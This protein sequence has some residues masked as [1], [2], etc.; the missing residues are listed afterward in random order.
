MN[1]NFLLSNFSGAK[2]QAKSRDIPPKSL[3]SLGFEGHAE[4]L[5]PP[6]P[7]LTQKTPTTPKQRVW[8]WVPFSSLTN[9]G[10]PQ[11]E[12]TDLGVSLFVPIWLVLPRCEAT[13]W[14]CLLKQ[15]CA[16]N[17]PKGFLHKVFLRPPRVMDVRAFG[18]RTSAQRTLFFLRSERWALLGRDVRPDI[19]P[20]VRRISRPKTLCFGCF[21]LP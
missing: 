16:K 17:Q 19:R 21:S 15:G 11:R 2:S 10:Y 4:L 8:L 14:V 13:D 9:S 3:V 5:A 12:G 18:S 1:T 6:P 7:P 20:D